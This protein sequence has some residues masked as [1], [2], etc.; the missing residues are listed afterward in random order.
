MNEERDFKRDRNKTR[1]L[2]TL[3]NNIYNKEFKFFNSV[4]SVGNCNNVPVN[5]KMSNINKNEL[6]ENKLFNFKSN[7]TKIKKK[8]KNLSSNSEMNTKAMKQSLSSNIL[9]NVKTS[10]SDNNFYKSLSPS[11]LD[12]VNMTQNTQIKSYINKSSSFSNFFQP[13]KKVDPKVIYENKRKLFN[14]S[15]STGR[16]IENNENLTTR[17]KTLYKTNTTFYKKDKI[18]KYEVGRLNKNQI[19][20]ESS[21]KEKEFSIRTKQSGSTQ[22]IVGNV[23]VTFS[24]HLLPL[25][26]DLNFNND[27]ARASIRRER[28]KNS[29]LNG[30]ITAPKTILKRNSS[31]MSKLFNLMDFGMNTGINSG[32]HTEKRIST[33]RTEIPPEKN[34]INDFDV[35]KL[36][37]Q[38]L[39][40]VNSY[41]L[42]NKERNEMYDDYLARVET[43]EII[44]EEI[45]S[46]MLQ[47]YI[48][49]NFINFNKY[50]KKG[51]VNIK[52]YQPRM[53]K[54]KFKKN[55]LMMDWEKPKNKLI[56][57]K[58]QRDSLIDD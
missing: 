38:Y 57:R 32:Y 25:L 28:R 21:D 34:E 10:S 19:L 48:P 31:R 35:K 53:I 56:V 55:N 40:G 45:D 15:N 54:F 58:I 26:P 30:N 36:A 23:K 39:E 7:A 46:H 18:S 22:K 47:C 41:L 8:F 51:N 24:N 1:S 12:K 3:T 49:G 33:F 50:S 9:K 16:L 52:L 4:N 37:N 13:F 5:L 6:N 27:M 2:L 44:R 20:D 29:I 42:Y 43:G 17:I 14:I 11:I